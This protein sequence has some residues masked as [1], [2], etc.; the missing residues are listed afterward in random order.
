MSVFSQSQELKLGQAF[1]VQ[2]VEQAYYPAVYIEEKKVKFGS[3]FEEKAVDGGTHE[4]LT[5][6]NKGEHKTA[7]Y[8]CTFK[9][10]GE[11]VK[12]T[13][14]LVYFF[15][16]EKNRLESLGLLKFGMDTELTYKALTL[17]NS[18]DVWRD[19]TVMNAQKYDPDN[20][21]VRS[22]FSLSGAGHSEKWPQKDLGLNSLLSPKVKENL[23]K[24]IKGE[25]GKIISLFEKY[26]E[27][28]LISLLKK[29]LCIWYK[30]L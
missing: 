14:A 18:F 17:T 8:Q 22:E 4:T 30:D 16:L 5:L 19:P 12:V 9:D 1:A 15:Q 6:N 11:D 25:D 20:S 21:G 29:S 13:I 10:G 23:F 24:C 7:T 28:I 27:K 3:A 26:V 2:L